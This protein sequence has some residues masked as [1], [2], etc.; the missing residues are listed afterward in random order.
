MSARLRSFLEL[1]ILFHA[2]VLVG[3]IQLL[4]FVELRSCFHA[5]CIQGPLSLPSTPKNS[6]FRG[7]LISLL[8]V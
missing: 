3:R 8:I 5:G 4:A 1:S 7:S 2:Y 6:L